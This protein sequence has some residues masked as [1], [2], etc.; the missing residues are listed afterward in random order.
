MLE[1][2]YM[3]VWLVLYGWAVLTG[4]Y[5]LVSLVDYAAGCY[6]KRLEQLQKVKGKNG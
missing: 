6:I 1:Y 5:F 3:L 2:G 4:L